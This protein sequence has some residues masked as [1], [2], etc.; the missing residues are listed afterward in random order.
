MQKIKT[1]TIALYSLLL[2]V[3][4]LLV[5]LM[6]YYYVGKLCVQTSDARVY[7]SIADNYINT[8]HFIQ[9]ARPYIG[10]V[11][12]PGTPVMITV[13]KMLGFS[14]YAIMLVQVLMFGISNIFL[15]EVGKKITGTGG[16]A[17]VMYTMAYLRC[18]FRLGVVMVEHYYLFLVCMAIW[19]VYSSIRDDKKIVALN[20]TGLAM[21]LTRPVLFPAYLAILL[22]SLSWSWKNKKYMIAAGIILLPILILGVNVSVNYKETG[23]I[24]LLEN[25]SGYDLYNAS[26]PDSPVTVKEAAEYSKENPDIER[27]NDDNT[28]TMTERNNQFKKLA[29]ENINNNFLVYLKNGCLRG[30]EL[31]IKQYYWATIYTLLGGVLLVIGE[32][33]RNSLNAM[34]ILFVTLMLAAISSFGV[35]ELRYSIVIWPTASVHGAYL[36]H[37][38]GKNIKSFYRNARIHSESP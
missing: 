12:P 2:I 31:F 18:Y 33:K 32:M 37:V 19:L 13:F 30:Y 11:V 35:I 29:K 17:P 38:I 9:T 34:V 14:N 20:A 10:M 16:W 21:V 22:Y 27:I 23:E 8:G 26:Q 1:K 25:Y 15:Y 3:P 36:T 4:A 6:E 24:I 28:L 5:L 7:I